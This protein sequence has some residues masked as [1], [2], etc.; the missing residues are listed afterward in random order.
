MANLNEKVSPSIEKI[1]H[2]FCGALES[3]N[4]SMLLLREV[5]PFRYTLQKQTNKD[6]LQIS[7]HNIG[8]QQCFFKDFLEK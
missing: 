6:L 8:Y 4:D 5:A 1:H 3:R 2:N 7:F